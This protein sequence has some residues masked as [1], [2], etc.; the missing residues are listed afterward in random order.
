MSNF[1]NLLKKI[2]NMYRHLNTYNKK[3]AGGEKQ[4]YNLPTTSLLLL[5]YCL[6]QWPVLNFFRQAPYDLCLWHGSCNF[7]KIRAVVLKLHTNILYRSRNYGIEFGWNRLKRLN[8]FRFWIFWEFSQN[9]L[10]QWMIPR[11]VR[12]IPCH[13][14]LSPNDSETDFTFTRN[15]TE[16]FSFRMSPKLAS[17]SETVSLFF[18]KVVNER[19]SSMYSI[20][21]SYHQTSRSE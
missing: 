15:H 21:N 6:T 13:Y 11:S 1:F 14:A 4:T 7:R 19:S 16:S 17:G 12:M 10:T 9:F 3:G 18:T 2:L 20:L 5:R 8:F